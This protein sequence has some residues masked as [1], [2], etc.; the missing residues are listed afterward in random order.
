MK[1][2]FVKNY[3][4]FVAGAVFVIDEK[5]KAFQYVAQALKDGVA[6]EASESEVEVA[7]SPKK[8]KKG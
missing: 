4:G 3:L 7:A 1:V 2:K 5:C 8:T 6:V